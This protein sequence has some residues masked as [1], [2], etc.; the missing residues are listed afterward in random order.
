M[1]EGQDVANCVLALEG[2]PTSDTR[3]AHISLAQVRCMATTKFKERGK[4]P[5][6]TSNMEA[7]S[8]LR[9][10]V[11]DRWISLRFGRR[12]CGR[13]N[14]ERAG[15]QRGSGAQTKKLQDRGTL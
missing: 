15:A 13:G 4:C 11:A 14:V 6:A 10:R 12:E 7:A 9:W 5:R 3:H 2:Y 1:E 8:Q